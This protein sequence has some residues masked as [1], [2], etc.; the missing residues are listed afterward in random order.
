MPFRTC[1]TIM[2]FFV[3]CTGGKAKGKADAMIDA[4]FSTCGQP[5]DTGNELGIGRFCTSFD[6]CASTTEAPLCSII[7]SSAT[8]FC[9]KTCSTTGSAGQ[10]GTATMCVCNAGNQ[11]GCTPTVCLH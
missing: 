2:M 8:H 5:G 11:C 10:C 1:I 4:F 3:A 9:T 6:D 7:G